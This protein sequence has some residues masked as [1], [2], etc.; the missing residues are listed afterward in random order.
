ME[1]TEA[2]RVSRCSYDN[3]DR[4]HLCTFLYFSH[5]YM[6]FWII[7]VAQNTA[8]FISDP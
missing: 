5:I 6:R 7:H 4:A 8:E 2:T 1:W 3:T